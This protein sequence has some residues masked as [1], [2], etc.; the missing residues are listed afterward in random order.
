MCTNYLSFMKLL[1]ILF[2][3][4]SLV[5]LN[6]CLQSSA[7]LGPGVTIITTGNI[8]QAGF[9][10]IAN[11]SIKKETGKNALTLVKEVVEE[12]HQKRKFRK[13]FK[14]MVKNRVLNAR[15]KILTN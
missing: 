12:D 4:L 13:D 11:E 10:Y 5:I 1:K 6:G 2:L 9:Q 7:L 3:F 15:K 14:M 8:P